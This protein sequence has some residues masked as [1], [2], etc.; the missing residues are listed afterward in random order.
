MNS[1]LLAAEPCTIGIV[2]ASQ[3][4]RAIELA[5]VAPGMSPADR[6]R[7]IA[8]FVDYARCP[9]VQSTRHAGAYCDGCLL[10]ACLCYVHADRTGMIFVPSVEDR[11][12]L[13]PAVRQLL[14]WQRIHTPADGIRLLQLMA[15]PA[16]PAAAP[17]IL[18][19]A[20]G[21][22]H[23]ADLHYLQCRVRED[24]EHSVATDATWLA[25]TPET[26]A[27]FTETLQATYLQSLD[28]PALAGVRTIEDIITG[29][30]HVGRYE[31]ALW[32]VLL[33]GGSPSGVLIAALHD[34]QHALEV[35]YMGI[36]PGAR[37]RGFAARLLQRANDL[38]R[39]S[40]M[41]YL[42]LAVDGANEPALRAY[43]RF[44]FTHRATRR[45]FIALPE[46]AGAA[47][48]RT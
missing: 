24:G 5:V 8:A 26:H 18:Y 7:Q 40:S 9:A 25:Y 42:T 3:S 35:V 37:G 29:H 22:R 36:V 28:C 11:P 15:D 23:L 17:D 33:T 4:L 14:V 2:P 13:E 39:M 21:F 20:A 30:R 43:L 32:Q 27:V 19:E 34:D 6:R 10:T 12:Q 38:A 48:P 46:P 16:S 1:A 41:R 45:A 31:P 47:A 44:G